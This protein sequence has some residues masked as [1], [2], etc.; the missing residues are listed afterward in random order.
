MTVIACIGHWYTDLL[1]LVP[2]AIMGVLVGR[3]KLRQRRA[4]RPARGTSRARASS[5]RP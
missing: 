2:V 1:Y 4:A 3:D 5:A